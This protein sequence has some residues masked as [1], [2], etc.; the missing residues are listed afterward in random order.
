VP[1]KRFKTIEA[2]FVQ[3]ECPSHCPTNIVKA[4]RKAVSKNYTTNVH[5]EKRE[6]NGGDD[7]T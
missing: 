3:A 4:Q 7:R 6:E 5:R 2:G 1:Q